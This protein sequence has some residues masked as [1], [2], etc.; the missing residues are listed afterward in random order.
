MNAPKKIRLH[1][2]DKKLQLCFA[3][4]EYLLSAEYLRVHSPSAEVRGHGADDGT[5]ISGKLHVGISNITAAGRYALQIVFDDG[6]DSGIYTW[7]Y[8]RELAEQKTT[9]W[10]AYLQQ[11]QDA[12]LYRNP[13]EK[14]IRFIG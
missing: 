13:D 14:A 11:L 2:A 3:N 12:G 8:L 10:Q 9:K 1:Q 7:N 4:R 6:H 5:L